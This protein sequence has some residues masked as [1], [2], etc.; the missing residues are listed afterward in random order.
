MANSLCLDSRLGRSATYL[1]SDVPQWIR[2]TLQVDGDPRA[3]VVGGFS[4]GGTCALQMRGAALCL[5][6]I[7]DDIGEISPTADVEGGWFETGDLAHS[8]GRGGIRIMGR[9]ADRIYDKTATVMIPVRDVEEE[10]LLHPDVT[11]VAIIACRDGMLEDVC[12]VVVPA[13]EPPTLDGLRAYLGE[14]GMT[15]WYHPT[16]LEL[17]DALPRDQLGKI[18][19]YQLRERFDAPADAGA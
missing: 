18:R 12:A 3:W 16:R 14:R 2:A 11:D 5:G 7:T 6:T 17:V 10:L 15:E 9:V 19:K 4:H 13:G 8:D 1:T